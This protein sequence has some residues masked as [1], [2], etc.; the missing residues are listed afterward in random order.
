MGTVDAFRLS[1]GGGDVA[2]NCADRPA[3]FE[4]VRDRFRSGRGFSLATLNLDHLVKLRRQPA[5]RR[6]YAKQDFVVADGNPVVWLSRLAGRPVSL[7]AGA[8]LVEPLARIAAEEGVRVAFV[9]ATE[10]TLARAG[11][12]LAARLPGLVI[13]ARIA[14]AHGFD[15]E[16]EEAGRVIEALRA[17]GARLVLVA[18]GAPKQEVFAARAAAALPGIG[19]ASIGAGLDF[20]AGSQ[21][22]APLWMRRIALEWLWRMGSEPRRLAGRYLG[23]AAAL[24]GLALGV[25]AGRAGALPPGTLARGR[26]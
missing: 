11:A 21:R 23:C 16:G 5:F 14:P 26:G 8:D 9:G 24:P 10:Q 17:S 22:R 13:A 25:L 6:A 12:A 15:P 2:V 1:V 19:F 20:L 3:L 7:V 18:L 4:A